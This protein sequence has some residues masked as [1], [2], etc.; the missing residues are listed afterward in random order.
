MNEQR[1]AI[2][3][4]GEALVDFVP[5]AVPGGG[6]MNV[7]I[8]ATRLGTWGVFAGCVSTDAFGDQIWAHLEDNEV[9]LTLASRSD[10]PTARAIVEHVPE[11]RFRFEGDDTADTQYEALDLGSLAGGPHILHGGTLGMFR[12]GT[13]ETLASAAESHEGLVSLDPNVRPQIIDDRDQWHHFHERWLPNVS[14]YKGSD[15]DLSWI[16]PDRSPDASAEALVAGGVGVV[17]ITKGSEG[18]SILT[19]AGVSSAPTP[20]V[21]V[22][23]TVGAGDTIVGAVLASL[24]EAGV[25]TPAALTDVGT[26]MWDIIAAR[27]VAAAGVTVSRAG[28]NPPYRH[29]L[30]WDAP[31]T[32]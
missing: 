25:A 26:D 13:A 27:A 14:I 16:W 5:D 21:E 23:D 6:P 2:V 4:A 8:A 32:P 31:A 18:L 1:T 12:G 7:A 20:T 28:A 17:I 9:D 10:A 29:E 15:E 24:A 22:I 30:E 19:S 3:S 11:L